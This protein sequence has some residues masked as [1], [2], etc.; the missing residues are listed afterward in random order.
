MKTRLLTWA[1]Y[2]SLILASFAAY[3]EHTREEETKMVAK[4]LEYTMWYP[5]VIG[6]GQSFRVPDY[7]NPDVFY[8]VGA[9][10]GWTRA[11]R[12]S[13]FWNFVTNMWQL[14]LT[15]NVYRVDEP[16]PL[17]AVYQCLHLNNTNAVPHIRR[18][19]L[20]PTF[21]MSARRRALDVCIEL[22]PVSD[23]MTLFMGNVLTNGMLFPAK[24]RRDA[25]KYADK[26]YGSMVSNLAERAVCDRAA[27]MIYH[28]YPRDDWMRMS[29][30]DDFLS[31][32]FDGYATSSNRLAFLDGM[33]SNTNVTEAAE[34]Q[35]VK[36]R[37]VALTNQLHQAP[38]PLPQVTIGAVPSEDVG[39]TEE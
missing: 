19:L 10:G 4:L 21:N 8:G 29:H 3:G 26:V 27:L 23:E 39:G 14:D 35:F 16:S 6:R 20:N 38:Q 5:D 1:V 37:F 13:A 36:A 2:G 18:L 32:Y 15:P 25:L 33:L 30:L 34:M 12:E 7:G 28:D 17:A 24:N 31:K 9:S 22:S 11:E